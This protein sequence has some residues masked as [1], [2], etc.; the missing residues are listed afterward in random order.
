[1]IAKGVLARL[2]CE[3]GGAEDD[4]SN[5]SCQS[6]KAQEAEKALFSLSSARASSMRV[7]LQI[8]MLWWNS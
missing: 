3:C 1:V 2:S 5:N 6:K 7:L 4:R 8:E